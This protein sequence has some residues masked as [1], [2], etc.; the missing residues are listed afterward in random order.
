M[1]GNIIYDGAASGLVIEDNAK[2]VFTMNMIV[3][4]EQVMPEHKTL[5]PQHD[6][7]KVSSPSL[8]DVIVV[9]TL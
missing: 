1:K 7:E 4:H 3:G 9:L 5:N 6:C 2:G 8:S